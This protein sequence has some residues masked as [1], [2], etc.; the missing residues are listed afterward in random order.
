LVQRTPAEAVVRHAV[1][2]AHHCLRGFQGEK[3][4]EK[5]NAA[6]RGRSTINRV[7]H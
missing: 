2:V 6:R 3:T 7:A 1:A 5:V 4:G